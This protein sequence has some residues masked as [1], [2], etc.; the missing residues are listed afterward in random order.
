MPATARKQTE[1]QKDLI[2]AVVYA[3]YS[4]TNQ[5]EQSIEGQLRDCYAYAEREGYRIV[6]EYIDR[7]LSAKTDKR[8]DFQKMIKDAEKRQFQAVIVWKLDRFARNRYDSA[9]YKARLKKHG[10][11]VVSAMENISDNPEGIILE[12]MLE[13]MA[14]YYSANLSQNIR[15]GQYDSAIKGQFIGSR[16]PIGYKLENKRLVIDDAKAWIVR[17]FFEEYAKG[18]S[19]TDIVA[20]LAAKGVKNAFGRELTSNYLQTTLRNTRYIGQ[21][22]FR[23]ELIPDANPPI[24]DE[25]TFYAVQERLTAKAHA[26]ATEKAIVN[27]LLSGKA[28]CGLCGTRLIGES[29]KSKTGDKHFYYTCSKRKRQK[30]CKKLNEKKGFLEWY[31]VEQT[32]EYV[33]TPE[34]INYIA[35]RVVAAYD[36]DFNVNKI[37]EM[38][39]R[40]MRLDGDINKA[41]D[42][43]L[44]APTAKARARFFEKIEAMETQKADIEIDLSRLKIAAGIKY[45]EE[46]IIVWLKQFCKG[47]LLDED[48]QSRIIDVFI[49]S[50]YV[51]DNKIVIYYNI[52]DGKQ[53]SYIEML[54]SSDEPQDESGAGDDLQGQNGVRFSSDELHLRSQKRTPTIL[55]VVMQ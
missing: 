7:A 38:E 40:L 24:I 36:T 3:R 48:F 10:V 30:D 2:P 41:V 54:E 50:V 13:S 32:I 12:G 52:K 28:F 6:G 19:K 17:Y 43:T 20:A 49:N 46:Q 1:K 45:T 37:K 4:S 9:T 39:G 22:V 47:D 26:P 25:K 14:E 21:Y 15:R 27:Y 31:V 16:P 42:A 11:K 33:L 44:E 18:V 34:R 5:K 29:G 55:W 23:G 35:A 51:Y 8:D 53:V